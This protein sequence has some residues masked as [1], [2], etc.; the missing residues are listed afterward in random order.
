MI[1]LLCG[2]HF[3]PVKL[4]W[5]VRESCQCFEQAHFVVAWINSGGFKEGGRG[6]ASHILYTERIMIISNT[7]NAIIIIIGQI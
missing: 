2:P 3:G 1:L 6:I 5:L 4:L 7:H